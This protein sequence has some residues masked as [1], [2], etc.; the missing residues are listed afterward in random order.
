MAK[1]TQ[2]KNKTKEPIDR[3]K[4]LNAGQIEYK[5]IIKNI[6]ANLV[7]AISNISIFFIFLFNFSITYLTTLVDNNK[8]VPP[9]R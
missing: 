3:V 6:T 9:L 7:Q 8:I 5:N 1:I 4:F 2:P